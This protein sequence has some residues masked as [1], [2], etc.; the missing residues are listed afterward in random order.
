MGDLKAHSALCGAQ[1]WLPFHTG[2]PFKLLLSQ[3]KRAPGGEFDV[4][5]LF[6]FVLVLCCTAER[7]DKQ[8]AKPLYYLSTCVCLRLR[9]CT[10]PTMI[11]EC[12]PTIHDCSGTFSSVCVCVS[13]I[14]EQGP[15]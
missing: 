9:S 12:E 4:L 15:H 14:A 11:C 13:R 8:E 7:V 2:S 3:V 6:R 10:D 1:L 5:T